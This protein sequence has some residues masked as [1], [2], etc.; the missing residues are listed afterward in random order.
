MF[1]FKRDNTNQNPLFYIDDKPVYT[2]FKKNDAD[3]I[4]PYR[5]SSKYLKSDEFRERYTLS[6]R[7]QNE[8][9]RALQSNI[10]P[11]NNLK[12][13]FFHIR[14]DLNQRLYTEIDLRNTDHKINW[15]FPMNPKE[16]PETQIIIGSSQCF[17]FVFLCIE[18]TDISGVGKTYKIVN[19]ITEALKRGKKRRFVY[20]SPELQVDS[21]LKKLMNTKRWQNWFEGI[22]VSDEA[23]EEWQAE[24]GGGEVQ[25]SGGIVS[26]VLF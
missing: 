6:K 5:N 19:E 13:K 21:T 18:N 2:T 10:V 14:R 24:N 20:V 23:Y 11:D 12:G 4:P 7:E 8:L 15:R 9:V 26:L 1:T 17:Q 25:T 22:D 3:R 16:W